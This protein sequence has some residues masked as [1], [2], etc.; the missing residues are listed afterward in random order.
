M[1]PNKIKLKHKLKELLNKN[2]DKK[3]FVKRIKDVE[4]IHLAPSRNFDVYRVSVLIKK[5]SEKKN[6]G[7]DLVLK[8]LKPHHPQTD[9]SNLRDR[10]HR[11]ITDLPAYTEQLFKYLQG[12]INNGTKEGYLVRFYGKHGSDIFEEYAGDISVERLF[13][14]KT[15]DSKLLERIVVAIAD[16]HSKWSTN[17]G[18]YIDLLSNIRKEENFSKKLQ[19]NL[20][21]ILKDDEENLTSSETE[22]LN[23]FF[24]GIESYFKDESFNIF[25]RLIHSDL[26]LGHIFLKY[27]NL[28]YSSMVEM[29]KEDL[30]KY[31]PEI[32]IVDVTGMSIGPRTFDLVD[33]LKHPVAI[34]ADEYPTKD[35]QRKLIENLV[36]LYRVKLFE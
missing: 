31:N 25:I 29:S 22:I 30:K 15:P 32:K 28:K 12:P 8:R 18:S 19:D 34:N 20:A 1:I 21:F 9:F 33:I 36:E 2:S 11:E 4:P 27:D 16:E 7:L 10:S 13:M 3:I 14:E 6:E 26:H 35:A 17:M 24:N 5:Q 23:K